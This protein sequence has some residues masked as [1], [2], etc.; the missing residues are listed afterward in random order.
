MSTSVVLCDEQLLQMFV[1]RE[2]NRLR[3]DDEL[4]GLE[5]AVRRVQF[6]TELEFGL[7]EILHDDGWVKDD[8]SITI[9]YRGSY[10]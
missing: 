9:S 6:D 4:V 5:D 8:G 7:D 2:F 1:S 10:E 3:T